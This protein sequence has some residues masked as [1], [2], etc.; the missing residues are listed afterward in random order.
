MDSVT[1]QETITTIIDLKKKREEISHIQEKI[2]E[3]KKVSDKD[4]IAEWNERNITILEKDISNRQKELK[5]LEK[6]DAV[7]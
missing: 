2:N 3:Y 5:K 7:Q 4:K 6:L 1:K